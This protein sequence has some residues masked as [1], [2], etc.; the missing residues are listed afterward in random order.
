M[1][2]FEMSGGAGVSRTRTASP[3]RKTTTLIGA[4][5]VIAAGIFVAST[6]AGHAG[7]SCAGLETAL[8]NNLNFIETQKEHPTAVSDANIANRVEVVKLITVRLKLAGCSTNIPD[9]DFI[10]DPQPGSADAG[11]GSDTPTGAGSATG[12]PQDPGGGTNTVCPGST[13]TLSGE[14][15]PPAASSG[16]FRA[17]TKLKVTN[18]DNDKS[19]T[20]TVTSPSGSCVLLNNTA[21][22]E[23][24]EPGKLVIRHALVQQVS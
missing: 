8:Q 24:H 22:N 12:A 9:H 23:I 1:A 18:L 16:Q 20:V 4:S 5:V 10:V 7:E 15:G 2:V 11:S 19:I 3:M 14:G 13:V 6:R 17:G 21:F